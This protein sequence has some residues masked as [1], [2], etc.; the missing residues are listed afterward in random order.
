MNENGEIFDD[1]LELRD[2][3][4]SGEV[5]SV[6]E[7]SKVLNK[8]SS[9][10]KGNWR[11]FEMSLIVEVQMGWGITDLR[12]HLEAMFDASLFRRYSIKQAKVSSRRRLSNKEYHP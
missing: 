6:E 7:Y 5:V 10:N 2:K 12:E 8:L 1:L 4:L 11:V 9:V 3:V